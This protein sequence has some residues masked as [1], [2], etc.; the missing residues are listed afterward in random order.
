[1]YWSEYDGA[2]RVDIGPVSGNFPAYSS[3]DL[4]SLIFF[5]PETQLVKVVQEVIKP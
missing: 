4:K 3:A 1:L 5:K 2:N